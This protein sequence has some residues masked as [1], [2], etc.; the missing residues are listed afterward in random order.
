MKR[1]FVLILMFFS[2]VMIREVPAMEKGVYFSQKGGARYNSLGLYG[3]S[4][5]FYRLPL[6]KSSDILWKNNK[7]DAGFQEEFSP[8]DNL[9]AVRLNVEPIAFFDVTFRY[10]VYSMFN[11]LGYGFYSFNRKEADYDSKS[12]KS[13]TPQS[14]SGSWLEVAPTLKA[15]VSAIVFVNTLSINKID[16]DDEDYFFLEVRSNSL[17]APKGTHW[18]NN[19]MLLYEVNDKLMAGLNYDRLYV[20]STKY[21]SDRLS[22]AFIYAPKTKR[23]YAVLLAGVS[24]RDRYFK[25]HPYVALQVGIDLKLR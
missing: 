24:L 3:D 19:S 14:K 12:L 8:A 5:I 20:N 22:S 1:Y 6:S 18:K 15:K 21:T 23:T 4:R 16:L 11:G 10:G 17:Q 7:I 9:L 25:G 13:L 2:F